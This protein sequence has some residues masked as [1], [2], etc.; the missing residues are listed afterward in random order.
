MYMPMAVTGPRP[1]LRFLLEPVEI[2]RDPILT[3][4]AAAHL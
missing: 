1:E 3:I 2:Q 4:R